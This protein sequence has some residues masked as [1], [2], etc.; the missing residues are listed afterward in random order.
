MK[1]IDKLIIEK[2]REYIRYLKKAIHFESIL[3]NVT[4]GVQDIYDAELSSLE[5]E[6][7]KEK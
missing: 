5:K 2:Q 1:T 7:P 4:A 6:V 3:R